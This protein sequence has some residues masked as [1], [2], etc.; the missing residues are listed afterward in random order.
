MV[1]SNEGGEGE[2][3]WPSCFGRNES[4]RSQYIGFCQQETLQGRMAQHG[5]RPFLTLLQTYYHF[6]AEEVAL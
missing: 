5:L 2:Y 6:V 3:I 1:S 4:L